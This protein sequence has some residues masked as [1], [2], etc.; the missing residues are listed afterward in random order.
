MHKFIKPGRLIFAFAMIALGALSISSQDFIVGRPP[1]W[2]DGPHLNQILVYISASL[3]IVAALAMLVSFKGLVSSLVIAVLIFFLTCSRHFFHWMQDWANM[4]KSWALTGGALIMASSFLNPSIHNHQTFSKIL[5][6]IGSLL[7]AIF[8][9]ASGYAHF[10]YADFVDTLIPDYIPFHPFWTRFCGICLIAGGLGLLIPATRKWA[11]FCSA[12][13]I[14]GWFLLLHI[15][16]LMYTPE[17]LGERMGVCE[18]FAFVGIMLV[19]AGL[20]ESR[21]TRIKGF[22]GLSEKY[23]Q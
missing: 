20:S 17:N 19:L 4:Y 5:P 6:G 14:G 16:R 12:I 10:K 9:L 22:R 3:L 1:G 15:P 13:M 18:S 7:V 23:V 11:A 2:L 21:I 8:F